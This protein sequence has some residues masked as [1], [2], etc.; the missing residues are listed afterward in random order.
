MKL[1]RFPDL[2]AR[3][4]FNSRMTLKRAIDTQD[5]PPGV[6]IT[7]NARAWDEDAINAWIASR[8]SAKKTARAPRWEDMLSLH[9]ATH[10]NPAAGGPWRRTRPAFRLCGRFLFRRFNR[11]DP[12]PRSCCRSD[13]PRQR[14]L[15]WLQ[16][17]DA[18]VF[19]TDWRDALVVLPLRL[20]AEIAIAAERRK[21]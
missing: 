14:L 4:L 16:G 6:L 13:V 5:F 1:L 2:I 15:S 10:E 12:R 8:P 18:L 17:R 21:S 7:P 3:G 20:A 11:H 9:D 19:R